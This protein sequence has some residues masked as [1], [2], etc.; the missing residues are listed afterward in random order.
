ML[1]LPPL[2]GFLELAAV[3]SCC[4]LT[5]FFFGALEFSILGGPSPQPLA[6]ARRDPARR[7][8]P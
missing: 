7:I 2:P 8:G 4:I 1:K 6:P 5:W 3:C